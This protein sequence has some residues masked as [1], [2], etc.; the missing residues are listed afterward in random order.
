M[1]TCCDARIVRFTGEPAGGRLWCCDWWVHTASCGPAG[2]SSAQLSVVL[3]QRLI[4]L[5]NCPWS[6][7]SLSTSLPSLQ[8]LAVTLTW[9]FLFFYHS[10]KCCYLWQ[11]LFLCWLV[12]APHLMFMLI[13]AIKLCKS[14]WLAV[15]FC[16][17]SAG[18]GT[19]HCLMLSTC[20]CWHQFTLLYHHKVITINH[21]NQLSTVSGYSIHCCP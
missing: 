11:C 13:G 19:C 7:N 5:M 14:A 10:V 4:Q 20:S 8:K 21:I 3:D 12:S 1:K 6:W 18:R 2:R 17:F 15:Y 16:S 9:R